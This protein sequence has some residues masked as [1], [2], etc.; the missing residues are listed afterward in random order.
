MI[1][2]AIEN[3]LTKTNERNYQIAFCQVLIHKGHG[4]IYSSLHRSMEQGKDI[5]TI[6]NNGEYNAYQL[7][8]GDIDLKKWREIKGEIN[9]LIEL[10]IVHSSID[11]NKLHK[12]FLVTN[13]DISDEVRIQIDQIN[14]DNQRKDRRYS[15]L[16]VI[17]GKRLLKYFVDSQGGF[18]PK[19]INEF[20]LFLE[21]FLSDGINFLPKEKYTTFLNKAI[22]NIIPK[23]KSDA[24]NAISSSVIIVSYLLNNY[25][26]K[27]NYYALFEAWTILAARIIRY[28]IT[29]QLKKED[30][31]NTYD[32]VLLEIIR[33][34]SLLKTDTLKREDFLEGDWRGDGGLIYRTRAT[35]VL[36]T[37]AAHEIYLYKTQDNFIQN[38]QLVE[39]IKNNIQILCIWGESAFPYIFAI[40]KYLEINNE[41]IISSDIIKVLLLTVIKSNSIKSQVAMPNPYYSANDVLKKFLGTDDYL[42]N[43]SYFSGG[44]YILEPI[45]LMLV[46][47]NLRNELEKNWREITYIQFKEFR[48]EYVE[49]MFLWRISEGFNHFEFPKETQSWQELV[50]ISKDHSTIPSLYMEYKD[51]LL[52]LILVFPHRINKMIINLL[53]Q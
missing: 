6:D 29:T 19:D 31:I 2:R 25:Q 36:G 24:I 48:P 50:T 39:L 23:Q 28:S 42:I 33:N 27:N 4:I 11:K 10:P 8:T 17:N 53:D 26:I 45:I 1:E 30:W 44:S 52:F 35:I 51:F 22:F 12:S 20:H 38:N 21:L 3:W 15:Y 47:R 9:E 13:G 16:D 46:S 49:D 14:D 43:L 5:A 32:L 7:K 18:I 34:L 40:I 37:L 41:T